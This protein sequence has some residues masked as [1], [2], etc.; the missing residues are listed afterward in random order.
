LNRIK[1]VLVEKNCQMV[2]RAV[3]KRTFYCIKVVYQHLSTWPCHTI[4]DCFAFRI[5]SYR[6]SK[7]WFFDWYIL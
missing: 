7:D 5:K 3:R 4:T 2:S 6:V 1:V